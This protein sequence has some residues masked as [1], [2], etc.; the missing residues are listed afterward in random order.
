MMKLEA[1][2][3]AL[4]TGSSSGIGRAFA[5]AL[6]ERGLH[7]V[8]VARDAARLE[9]V[10]F[11]IL[12]KGSTA[13]V[14]VADL[15]DPQDLRR[16]E[17]RLG[18]AAAVD[19]FVNNAALGVSGRFV[20]VTVEA[21][22]RQI[23]VNVLAPTRLAHAAVIGMRSRKRG[24]LINVSSGT[25]FVPSLYNAA[26][27]ATKAYLGILSLTIAEELRDS[28]VEVVTVYPGF[29]RT[30][31]QQRAQFDVSKVPAFLWQDASEVVAEA[32]ASLE[33]GRQFCVPGVLNKVAI[34]LNHLVPY[35]R[36]GW[37]AGLVAGLTPQPQS[38]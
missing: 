3:T 4:V 38:R 23:L 16:V 20:D 17:A 8:L 10:A 14:L 6:A 1:G 18:S 22:E 9:Q 26:Y 33:S 30:E 34:A 37:V 13:E 5:L 36:M 25:A 35:S 12:A 31:F 28:G 21:A 27:S 19:L 29:T 32:L 11:E 7:L 24:A 2:Q 15:G